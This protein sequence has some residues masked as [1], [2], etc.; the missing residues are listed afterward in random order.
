M[1]LICIV[2]VFLNFPLNFIVAVVI[3]FSSRSVARY[4]LTAPERS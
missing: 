3:I 2:K 4:P 1:D